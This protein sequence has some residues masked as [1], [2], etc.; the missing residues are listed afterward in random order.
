MRDF[1]E[2]HPVVSLIAFF[3]LLDTIETCCRI[4]FGR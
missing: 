4:I 1:I 3:L 2:E